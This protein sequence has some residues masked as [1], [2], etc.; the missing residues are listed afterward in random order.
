MDLFCTFITTIATD[1]RV[2]ITTI[3]ILILEVTVGQ[4]VV[5]EGKLKDLFTCVT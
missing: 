2:T 3:N 4:G 1:T 5:T